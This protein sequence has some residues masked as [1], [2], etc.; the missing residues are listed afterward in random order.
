MLC[1]NLTHCI[2]R[3]EPITNGSCIT[4]HFFHC[5]GE[6]FIV[7][8]NLPNGD[9]LPIYIAVV[10]RTKYQHRDSFGTIELKLEYDVYNIILSYTIYIFEIIMKP[11]VGLASRPQTGPYDCDGR[12]YT[13]TTLHTTQFA[14]KPTRFRFYLEN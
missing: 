2:L 1:V 11:I 4:L 14:S 13:E 5:T 10:V 7:M 3:Y 12:V 9:L 6:T 8:V